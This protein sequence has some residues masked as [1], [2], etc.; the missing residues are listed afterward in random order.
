M[1]KVTNDGSRTTKSTRKAKR[2]STA[3]LPDFE[4]LLGGDEVTKLEADLKD[5]KGDSRR[6]STILLTKTRG[7]LTEIVRAMNLDL[8][9]ETLK[10]IMQFQQ[11]A[12]LLVDL[13]EVAFY[14]FVVCADAAFPDQRIMDQ[15]TGKTAP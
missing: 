13:S 14:R 8:A 2:P 5:G 6:L 12:K 11:D 9:T 15:V 3:T 1:S 10:H 4:A 7:E